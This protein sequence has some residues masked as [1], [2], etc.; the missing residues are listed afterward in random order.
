MTI[1]FNR[2][3]SAVL[4]TSG[5]FGALGTAQANNGYQV[6]QAQES[7]VSLGMTVADVRQ[8]L[9]RPLQIAGY[10]NESGPAWIYRVTDAMEPTSF[11][12]QFD[13]NGRVTS[14]SGMVDADVSGDSGE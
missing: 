13:A 10:A 14:A 5:L 1:K 11:F 2:F 12:V 9:G 4:L 3:A 8:A 6:S 7:K